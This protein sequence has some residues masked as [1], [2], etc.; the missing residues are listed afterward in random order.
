MAIEEG[1]LNCNIVIIDTTAY[2]GNFERELCAYVTG[3]IAECLVGDE[4]ISQ[5]DQPKYLDWWEDHIDP[6]EDIEGSE[7]YRPCTIWKTNDTNNSHSVA[8]F[9]DDFPPQEVVDE[10]LERAKH[11][12]NDTDHI[13]KMHGVYKS[14]NIAK[15]I[16][17]LS[18]NFVESKY[19]RQVIESSNVTT[20]FK[21]K[22]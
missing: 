1:N 20:V 6:Q 21:K 2:A 8:I 13:Y 3:Q 15:E 14:P 5:T 7:F 12:L 22:M 4:F 17:I 10:M 19:T 9:V 18:Y 16:E 11:F